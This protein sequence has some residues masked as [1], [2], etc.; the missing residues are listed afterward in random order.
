LDR[1]LFSFIYM[2]SLL[3]IIFPV[4]FWSIFQKF[5]VEHSLFVNFFS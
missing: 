2:I 5:I 4:Y 1:F 3:S